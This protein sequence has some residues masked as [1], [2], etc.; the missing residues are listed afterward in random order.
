V[1]SEAAVERGKKSLDMIRDS[2]SFIDELIEQ[3]ELPFAQAW[4]V[5]WIPV[6]LAYAHQS[7][8]SVRHLRQT[9]LAHLQRTLITQELLSNPQVDLLLIFNKIIFPTLDELLKPQVFRRDPVAAGMGETRLRAC[10]L[11]CKIFLHCAATPARVEQ[12]QL[13]G[14]WARVLDALDRMMHSG[15]RDAMVRA[16]RRLCR[17]SSFAS[18]KQSQSSLKTPSWSCQLKAFWSR[19]PSQVATRSR[20]AYGIRPSMY[21]SC[22]SPV[23][24][25]NGL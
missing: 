25:L 12:G 11:L 21:V 15:R 1:I 20:S 4:E 3:S 17:C 23:T 19:P 24:S 22:F 7:T 13:V 14:I 18:T 6:L 8:N 16:R 9:S 2:Q 10:A 5:Y